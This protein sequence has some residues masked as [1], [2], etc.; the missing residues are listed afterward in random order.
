MENQKTNNLK[1]LRARRKL[2]IE[3]GMD[4]DKKRAALTNVEKQMN[5]VVRSIARL[6]IASGL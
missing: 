4:G 3:S 5:N 6:R 1:D 2:I